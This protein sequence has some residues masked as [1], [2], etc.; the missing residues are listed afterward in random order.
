MSW[1]VKTWSEGL[2]FIEKIGNVILKLEAEKNHV[3]ENL[4]V[5]TTERVKCEYCVES[6][7]MIIHMKAKEAV[8][9][10]ILPR[11]DEPIFEWHQGLEFKIEM[12]MAA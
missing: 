7:N 8:K 3:I 10:K 12:L 5:I 6:M 11:G 9:A 4:H 2:I 1:V